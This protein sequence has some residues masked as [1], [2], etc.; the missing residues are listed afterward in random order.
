[1]KLGLPWFDKQE[2]EENL[3]AWELLEAGENLFCFNLRFH[4]NGAT[5]TT[6]VVTMILLSFVR[7]NFSKLLASIIQNA[8]IGH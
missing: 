5:P 7:K 1:M 2:L 8:F 6:C 3:I 4:Q